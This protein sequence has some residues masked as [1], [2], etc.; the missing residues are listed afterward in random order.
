MRRAH[1]PATLPF[2]N[3]DCTTACTMTTMLEIQNK[4]ANPETP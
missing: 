3:P 1:G 2:T 4:L